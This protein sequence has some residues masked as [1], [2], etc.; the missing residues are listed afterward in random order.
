MNGNISW[1]E[2]YCESK[3]ASS[4]QAIPKAPATDQRV[5][6]IVR[7]GKTIAGERTGAMYAPGC[8]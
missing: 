8:P 7:W 5:F 4:E 3:D 2:T 1:N 6:T